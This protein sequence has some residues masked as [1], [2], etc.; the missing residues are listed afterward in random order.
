VRFV[1][2]V[3]LFGFFVRWLVLLDT[4]GIAECPPEVVAINCR[5]IGTWMPWAFLLQELFELLLRCC[6]PTSR[7]MIHSRDE[8]VWL[9]LS[10]WTRVV[11][12]ALVSTVVIWAPQ[13]AVIAPREP[14]PHL[15]LLL[16]PVVH[17]VAEP[18]NS[19]R[20]V[21]PK[22]SVDAWVGDAV[23]EAVDD[24]FLRDIRNGDAHVE[25]TACIGP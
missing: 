22:V 25:E 23:V 21:L 24:V 3:I 18:Y 6:L 13:V 14:L 15:F 4:T 17:H 9:A 10:G 19:F 12:L 11:P 5:M 16:G 20:S 7:R 1:P 8:V 2:L